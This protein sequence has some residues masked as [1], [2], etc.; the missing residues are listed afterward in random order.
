MSGETDVQVVKVSQLADGIIGSEI[1]KLASEVNEKI[2]P[3]K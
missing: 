1:I 3:D 2:K